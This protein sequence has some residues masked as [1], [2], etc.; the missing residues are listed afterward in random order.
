MYIIDLTYKVPL[1]EV[2][3]YLKDHVE[4]LDQQYEKGYFLASGRKIPR[5][6]GVILSNM[7]DKSKLLTVL[8]QDPFHL[9]NIAEYEIIEFVPSKTS[10]ELEFLLE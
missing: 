4:F 2:E 7:S 9:H 5:T 10:K 3:K 1:E 6:G 8:E